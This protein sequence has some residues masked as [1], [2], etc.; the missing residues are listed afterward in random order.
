MEFLVFALLA[1]VLYAFA[2]WLLRRIEAAAGRVLEQRSLIFFAIL[3][4]LALLCFWIVRR[5]I[6]A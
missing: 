2:D 4:I 1:V 5:L 3:L 6:P